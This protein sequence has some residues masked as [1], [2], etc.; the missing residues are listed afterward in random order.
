MRE[1]RSPVVLLAAG[2]AAA[3]AGA[4]DQQPASLESGPALD[5]AAETAQAVTC[6]PTGT[7]LTAAVVN[8]SV[9]DQTVDAA[10][11]NV[12]IFLDEGGH[13]VRNATVEAGGSGA[14]SEQ[15]GVRVVGAS[16]EVS[17]STFLAP[18]DF[19]RQLVQVAYVDGASGTIVGNRIEGRHRAGVLLDG[20]GT[21]AT[22]RD[23][24][25]VG[26]GPLED[27]WAENGVQVS[28]G[29]SGTVKRNLIEGHWWDK[30]DFTSSGII[31]FNADEVVASHNVVRDNDVGI[32]LQGDRNNAHHNEV[33]VTFADGEVDASHFGIWVVTGK[34]NGVR[35]N[36]IS[37]RAGDI[38]LIV[39]GTNSK[40]IRNEISG[41][42]VP[43]FDGGTDT[44]LPPPFDP[45]S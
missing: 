2:C 31:V 20:Q 10:D 45:S 7:G 23:N 33:E 42:A 26:V 13:V 39:Q 1:L 11:C 8:Q 19:G 28:R 43:I 36:E 30:N 25:I 18:D 17:N 40:L 32:A 4:C 38:G 35:Q 29:A 3:L 27:G 44:K 34:N 14:P 6:L 5:E 41:W 24:E 16:A 37:A 21:S 9:V 22:V 15:F 12:G